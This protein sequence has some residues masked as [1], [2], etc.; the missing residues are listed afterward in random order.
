METSHDAGRVRLARVRESV[1][2]CVL[3]GG[4]SGAGCGGARDKESCANFVRWR[5]PAS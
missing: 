1:E 3:R 5:E 2:A 4:L